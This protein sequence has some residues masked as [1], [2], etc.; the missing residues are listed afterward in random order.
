MFD[1][2]YQKCVSCELSRARDSAEWSGVRWPKGG[3]DATLWPF[4]EAP[5]YSLKLRASKRD[6]E[7][8]LI[9]CNKQDHEYYLKKL[10]AC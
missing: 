2:L 8:I 5:D 3:F 4:L 10:T 1:P 6:R 9:V 7:Q